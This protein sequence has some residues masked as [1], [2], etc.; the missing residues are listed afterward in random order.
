MKIRAKCHNCG[1][2]N[3]LQVEPIGATGKVELTFACINC[4]ALN[5][6]CIDFADTSNPVEDWLCLPPSGFEWALPSGR[7]KPAVGDPIYVSAVG[8][9]LSRDAYID[10]YKVDPEIAFEYMRSHEGVT[11]GS[12]AS[13]DLGNITVSQQGSVSSGFAD[14]RRQIHKLWHRD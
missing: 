4:G 6:I 12:K 7:I 9:Y 13:S 5:E 3:E 2:V 10:R 1:T 14:K 8:E 11:V